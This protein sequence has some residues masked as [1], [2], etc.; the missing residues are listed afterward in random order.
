MSQTH[1]LAGVLPDDASISP[2]WLSTF[3]DKSSPRPGHDELYLAK[4]DN[5]EQMRPKPIVIVDLD[6]IHI[7]LDLTVLTFL[8]VGGFIYFRRRRKKKRAVAN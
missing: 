4:S 7:H 6:Y 3:M 8:L 1:L 2:S 5:Q